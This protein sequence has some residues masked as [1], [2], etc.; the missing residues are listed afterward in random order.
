MEVEQWLSLPPLDGSVARGGLQPGDIMMKQIYHIELAGTIITAGQK[1]AKALRWATLQG[2]TADTY[3]EHA[4]IMIDGLNM[5]ESIGP[6]VTM[7]VINSGEHQTTPYVVF[8][9]TNKQLAND[10]GQI[11]KAFMGYGK[12][13]NTDRSRANGPAKINPGSYAAGGG[14]ATI[15]QPF[16]KTKRRATETLIDQMRDFITG[17]SNVRPNVYCTQFVA[18]CYVLAADWS[19]HPQRN[20]D[21]GLNINPGSMIPIVY[22][23]CLTKSSLFHI[24]GRYGDFGH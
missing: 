6:G 12:L 13:F 8:R 5:V 4:G 21:P 18:A 7:G 2:F 14:T 11:A 1:I 10:A 3:N 17:K 16:G 24:S 22:V 15:F 23:Q 9:C 20:T 19:A